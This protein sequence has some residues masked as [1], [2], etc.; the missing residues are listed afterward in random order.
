MVDYYKILDIPPSASLADIKRAYR[1]KVLRWHPDKNPDNRKEAERKFKEIVEAYK[2]LSDQST[3]DHYNGSSNNTFK[4]SKR[5]GSEKHL[6]VFDQDGIKIFFTGQSSSSDFSVSFF[7]APKRFHHFS[8]MTAFINGKKITTK[9]HLENESKYLEVEEDG[10]TVSV[11]VNGIPLYDRDNMMDK[12]HCCSEKWRFWNYEKRRWADE[13]RRWANKWR[14]W[15]EECRTWAEGGH[16][17]EGRG[18]SAGNCWADAEYPQANEEHPKSDKGFKPR[19]KYPGFPM[20]GEGKTTTNE[21]HPK[22]N[23]GQPQPE[24]EL[25]KADKGYFIFPKPGERKSGLEEGNLKTIKRQQRPESKGNPGFVRPGERHKDQDEVQV[26][27]KKGQPRPEEGQSRLDKVHSGLQKPDQDQ[28]DPGHKKP[29]PGC[30]ESPIK[31]RVVS[32]NNSQAKSRKPHVGEQQQQFEENN[33]HAMKSEDPLGKNELKDEKRPPNYQNGGS[34]FEPKPEKGTELHGM[35]K[36]SSASLKITPKPQLIACGIKGSLVK[37]KESQIRIKKLCAKR[38]RSQ[39]GRSKS[40]SSRNKSQLG[41]TRISDRESKADSEGNDVRNGG[42][43]F[44]PDGKKTPVDCKWT[45]HSRK[46]G[47]LPPLQEDRVQLLT[48]R[49]ALRRRAH[50]LPAETRGEKLQ[51]VSETGHL[52]GIN[53]QRRGRSNK[54]VQSTAHLPGIRGQKFGLNQLPNVTR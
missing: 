27:T 34:F 10:K 25:P 28:P 40:C 49:K 32:E 12:G 53:S 31:L 9:R 30:N 19:G 2:A 21:G 51:S 43:E 18:P 47:P 54:T 5:S 42:R 26:R 22:T 3:Q 17:Q 38:S 29:D 16:Y 36:R 14:S 37:R 13:W 45:L 41:K 44:A 35:R 46:K 52:L 33:Q 11:H 39:T 20:S 4:G 23:K 48:K 24:D 8:I 6:S 7:S 1:S 15:A 50:H